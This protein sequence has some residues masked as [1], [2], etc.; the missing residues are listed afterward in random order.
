MDDLIGKRKV[1]GCCQDVPESMRIGRSKTVFSR[2]TIDTLIFDIDDTL[3]PVE[4]GFTEFRN[5]DFIHKYL[6]QHHGFKTLKDAKAFRDEWFEKYHSTVKGLTKASE[7]GLLKGFNVRHLINHYV[8]ACDETEGRKYL[9]PCIDP[10]LQNTLRELI[11]AGVTLCIFTNGPRA[12]GLRVLET[13]GLRR[14]FHDRH[15]FGVDS[16]IP[17]CKPEPEAFLEVL[18]RM[19]T[20]PERAVMFEDSVKNIVACK[21]L[22]MKTVLV[23][24]NDPTGAAAMRAYKT[25]G[26][27]APK[28][29]DPS[30]DVVLRTCGEMRTKM[31]Y[32]FNRKF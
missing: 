15:I 32:L 25:K 21:K 18:K 2:D 5:S 9:V 1:S 7:E 16:I 14:Y 23:T 26:G 11:F 24:G 29:D 17:H 3:Y 6:V 30:V 10:E 4:C 28:V 20:T 12:Y 22:G 13:L 19:K 8:T 27:D 31:P